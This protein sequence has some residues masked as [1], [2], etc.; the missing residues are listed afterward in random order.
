MPETP[1]L[2]RYTITLFDNNGNTLEI[3]SKKT[4]FRK[5][6]IKNAQLLVNGKA[7]MVKGVNIHE[8]D[9]V[10]GHVPNEQLMLKDLQLMKEHNIN[11][12]RMCHYPHDTRFYELC[13]EYG[14]YVVD[15]ANIETH[16]M[17]S[18]VARSF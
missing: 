10:N 16:G 15:E 17:E 13:D 3:I 7:V 11:S 5:V 1:N 18:G 6:E 8:H 12:I 2:Y 9:D 4:G 14:F